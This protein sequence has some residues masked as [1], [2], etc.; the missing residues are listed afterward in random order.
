M[1]KNLG[2]CD[3]QPPSRAEQSKNGGD[4]YGDVGCKLRAHEN[5]TDKVA[6][7]TTRCECSAALIDPV[8]ESGGFGVEARVAMRGTAARGAK[9][10]TK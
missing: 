1:L 9:H 7:A 4:G 8:S 5:L 3:V 2:A 10:G 6:T